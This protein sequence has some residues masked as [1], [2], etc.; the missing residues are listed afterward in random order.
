MSAPKPLAQPVTPTMP[1]QLLVCGDRDFYRIT[2]SLLEAF[3]IAEKLPP[4]QIRGS[5]V[6]RKVTE[7]PIDGPLTVFSP[8]KKNVVVIA[9]GGLFRYELGQANARRYAPISAKGPLSAWPDP[10]AA[11]SFHVHAAGSEKLEDYALPTGDSDSP[12]AAAKPPRKTTNL[13]GFDA[14]LFTLLADGAPLYSTPKGLVRSGDESHPV[15]FSE[16]SGP[17]VILFADAAPD[18][19]W[20][21]DASGKLALFDQKQGA[22]PMFTANVPG[23]VLDTTTEGDR[24]GVLSLEVVEQSYRPT[25]TIFSNG[26][27]QARLPLG[28]S[29]G[30][31][32]QPVL[33]LC[34]VS[35]RPWFVVGGTRWLQLLDW[36]SHRLL[37]EW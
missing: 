35:G 13:P 26:K 11:N 17:A 29:F 27:E 22:A 25:V 4:P 24:V 8:A 1:A 21:A 15:P 33:D 30:A 28:P 23:V 7:V 2:Q 6:A 9:K 36:E 18:R 37:A 16:P 5:R 19:F 34:L 32:E 10:R 20:S 14:R 12:K 31:R 3:E